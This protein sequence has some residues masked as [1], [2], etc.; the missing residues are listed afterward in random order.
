MAPSFMAIAEKRLMT[1][2]T[3][4]AATTEGLAAETGSSA[5]TERDRQS[6]G[7]NVNYM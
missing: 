6:E 7:R 5:V 2:T 3:R 1:E 4:R